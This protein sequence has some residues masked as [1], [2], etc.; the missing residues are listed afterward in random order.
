MVTQEVTIK[1]NLKIILKS[2]TQQLDEVMVVAYGTAKKSSFTGSAAVVDSKKLEKRTVA[3]VSKAIEGTIPGVQTTVGSG[4]PGTGASI[5]VRGFGS[6][7]ASNAPLYVVDG[8]PYDGA[9]NTINPADIETLTVLK[10]ASAG[11]LY[12]ARGANG[13]VLITTK[14]GKNKDG[15]INIELKA[16]WGVSHRSV[17][18]YELLDEAGFIQ[19]NFLANRNV[20]IFNKGISPEDAG[21][22]AINEMVNG[23]NRIFGAIGSEKYNPYDMPVKDL[24]D[25]TTGAINPNAKLKYHYNWMDEAIADSPLRQDYQLNVSGG[26]AKTK[27][28]ISFGYLNEDGILKTT[29]FERYT[30]RINVD[31]EVKDWLKIG[32]NTNLAYTTTNGSNLTG[33]GTPSNVWES[34]MLMGPIYPVY[35]LDENYNPLIGSDGKKVFDYGKGSRPTGAQQ[36]FNSIATLYDDLYKAEADNVSARGFLEIH[37]DDDKYGV[38]KGISLSTNLGIDNVNSRKTV[39]YNPYYGNAA[40]AKGRVTKTD[41]RTFSVTFNQLLKYKREF[42]KHSV[43]F[44]AGHES[45]SRRTNALVGGRTGFPFDGLLELAPGTT[46]SSANSSE[47]KYKIESYLTQLN[48]GFDDKYYLSGSFRTDGTSRFHKD[49]R[50]GKFWS[51][52][53]SWRLSKEHFMDGCSD[54]LNNLTV[55]ASYGSQGNDDILDSNGYSILYAWQSF[56]DLSMANSSLNGSVLSSLENKAIKWEKNNNFN[57]GI[58]TR[59][60]NRVDLSLEYYNR[61]TKDMLMSV[62]MATSLGFDAY[63]ANVGSMRNS[64]FEL[65][66][67]VDIFKN[68]DFSWRFTALGSTIKN[69]ILKLVDGDIKGTS[70]INREGETMSSYFLPQSAGVDP[71]TGQRLYWVWDTDKNG[72]ASEK[73]ISTDVTKAANSREVCGSRI[74]D[75]YG[76]INNE[77]TFKGFDLSFLATYS[78][79]GKILD[80]M[81]GNLMNPLKQGANMH[82]NLLERAWKQPGDIT[83]VPRIT[84][85]E[86]KSYTQSDLTNASYL[87]IK[88]ITLGYTVPKRL[89]NKLQMSTIRIFAT[90][91]NLCVFSKLKGLDPQASLTGASEYAYTPVRTISFGVNVNF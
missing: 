77:F 39:Y 75:V 4:Q 14:Q 31:S 30:G 9:L 56:Y 70:R 85:T 18:A 25:P 67:G 20:A 88:N 62:P 69:K 63:T 35:E 21:A 28:L 1:P 84:F 36:D 87:A 59:L 46:I 81:Y 74:P 37:F 10:D 5:I 86:N 72:V 24:I 22:W 80:G 66:L 12:G 6:L 2:D 65:S 90:A 45:Y 41:G 26:N 8:I 51:V 53:A 89:L 43:D 13:V 76:S 83:D 60:F 48:Y 32:A 91:D 52:G 42:G 17:P 11:A 82:K 79:G 49:S 47:D 34:A 19:A 15:K 73:Y 29:S 33:S 23:N 50:W 71:A 58:E 68:N 44:L 16:T 7:T 3:T 55:K 54:W 64:G 27:Y 57:T 61:T 38:F 40:S 78:I